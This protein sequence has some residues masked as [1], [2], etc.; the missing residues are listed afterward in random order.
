VSLPLPRARNLWPC[1]VVAG[2]LLAGAGAA[3][4]AP[5]C[6]LSWQ[7]AADTAP[8][9]TLIELED[10]VR[11]RRPDA[12]G[13]AVAI[14]WAYPGVVEA[15]TRDRRRVVELG[16]LRGPEAARLVAVAVLDVLR[17]PATST[18]PDSEAPARRADS[19]SDATR[20][21]AQAPAP[22][23]PGARLRLALGAALNRG[24]TSAGFA[25]EPTAAAAL[26]LGALG[27]SQ[28][29][30]GFEIG[31]GQGRGQVS[32]KTF[33]VHM[34]PLRLCAFAARGRY[35]VTAGA[36]LRPYF[37]SG[38]GGENGTLAG[39]TFSAE[40]RW[41]VQRSWATTLAAGLDLPG[42]AV[43]FHVGGL[44]LLRTGRVVPWLR[45]G[46]SWRAL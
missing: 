29:G 15:R 18:L 4:A 46:M 33:V 45:A 7:F 22:V 41:P 12:G 38:W 32:T 37:S 16:P 17:P 34:I 13:E 11:I 1:C 25:L 14:R 20:L 23:A 6:G 9:F 35:T 40:G 26:A 10:A 8:P 27:A 2:L 30:L 24:A 28:L 3:L 42:N 43:D 36:L 21:S 39:G 5:C 44:S 19:A 31:Y